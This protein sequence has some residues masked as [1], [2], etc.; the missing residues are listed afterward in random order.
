MWKIILIV[1]LI[2]KLAK[3]RLKNLRKGIKS[4]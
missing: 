4:K 1:K 2:R 3:I